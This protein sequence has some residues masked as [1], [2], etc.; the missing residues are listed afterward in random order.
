MSD[1]LEGF[2]HFVLPK[3]IT[4]KKFRNLQVGDVTIHMIV[5]TAIYMLVHLFSCFSPWDEYGC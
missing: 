1:S 4:I 3:K 2:V 5:K